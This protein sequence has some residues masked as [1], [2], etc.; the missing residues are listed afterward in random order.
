MQCPTTDTM[1]HRPGLGD[2]RRDPSSGTPPT[3]RVAYLR[4]RYSDRQLSDEATGLLL[5]SWRNKSAQSYDSLCKKWISWCHQR[6][7]DPV[8]GPIEEVVNFLAHLLSE[9]YQYRSLKAYRSAIASLH[10][11]VEGNSVGQHPLVARL[12]KGAFHARTPLPRYS[13]TWDV[14]KVLSYLSTLKLSSDLPLKS[15]TYKTVILLALTR[16]SRSADLAKLDISNYRL[17]PEGYSF[18]PAA[19]PKQV[20]Q[21]KQI[22][23][24]FWAKFSEDQNLCPVA[25]LK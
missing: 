13:A 19:L 8:S 16:P 5:S 3:S 1:S 10:A 7:S 18:K 14:S 6:E 4:Q 23:E 25:T 21:G 11:P 24:Y 15:L 9:G 17:I 20:R 22:Q 2:L 12:L